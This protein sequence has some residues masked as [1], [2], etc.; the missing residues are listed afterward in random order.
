MRVRRLCVELHALTLDKLTIQEYLLK[1]HNIF[2]SMALIGDP[3]PASHHIDV[4]LEGVP[5]KVHM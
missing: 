5:S 4:I 3:I 2:D 1:V